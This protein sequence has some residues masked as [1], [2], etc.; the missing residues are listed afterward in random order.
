M[1]NKLNIEQTEIYKDKIKEVFDCSYKIFHG[2]V[3]AG[4][5]PAPWLTS[6]KY[7]KTPIFCYLCARKRK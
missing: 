7:K 3:F 5:I 2:P 6:R 1:D 4:R